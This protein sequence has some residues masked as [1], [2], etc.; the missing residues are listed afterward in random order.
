VLRIQNKYFGP[1]RRGQDAQLE[2]AAISQV[3]LGHQQFFP[4]MGVAHY[5]ALGTLAF[6]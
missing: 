1:I 2:A 5:H 6:Y 4:G 3:N